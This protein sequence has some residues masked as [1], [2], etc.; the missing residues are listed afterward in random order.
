LALYFLSG[1]PFGPPNNQTYYAHLRMPAYK[2]ADIGFS[3][4]LKQEDKKTGSAFINKFK[5]ILLNLEVFNLFGINNTI[6][7]N[8][9]TVVPNSSVD[10]NNSYS[11][12]AVPNRLSARRLNIR[13]SMDF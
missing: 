6:S 13:L 1:L 12:F 2:R 10:G 8:W 4:V 7:Y 9:I 3:I 11:S 5:N